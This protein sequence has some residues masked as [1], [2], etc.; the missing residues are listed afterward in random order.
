MVVKLAKPCADAQFAISA[1]D[2]DEI[3]IGLKHVQAA[4]LSLQDHTWKCHTQSP[5][6]PMHG[7]S[8]TDGQCNV[9]DESFNDCEKLLDCKE[10]TT[11][12]PDGAIMQFESPAQMFEFGLWGNSVIRDVKLVSC[13]P[14]S[15]LPPALRHDEAH[16]DLEGKPDKQFRVLERG[17]PPPPAPIPD[18]QDVEKHDE[19][20]KKKE[21][22]NGSAAD[23]VSKLEHEEPEEN[24]SSV[25][26][27]RKKWL[28]AT[29]EVAKEK[30]A[31]TTHKK[32]GTHKST[33]V[34]KTAE[35]PADA[36]HDSEL[37]RAPAP[38]Q[39][40]LNTDEEDQFAKMEGKKWPKQP[41]LN[42]DQE[43]AFAAMDTEGTDNKDIVELVSEMIA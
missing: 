41:T 7:P 18:A 24:L 1:S 26:L 20:K 33:K 27:L 22:D 14:V 8:I 35:K 32:V 11:S 6:T 16:A 43:R 13:T 15:D 25:E 36:G 31:G 29:E 39:G 4:Y 38:S 12:L 40:G 34:I 21:M 5:T 17:P 3:T 42:A 37:S 30:K 28:A 9:N 10:G 23:S 2:D 19:Q